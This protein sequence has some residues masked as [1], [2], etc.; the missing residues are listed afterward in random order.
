VPTNEPLHLRAS[1]SGAAEEVLLERR[2]LI[3]RIYNQ[4]GESAFQFTLLHPV[5]LE[6]CE[7][8]VKGKRFKEDDIGLVAGDGR[9]GFKAHRQEEVVSMS[10]T[11][12]GTG[13]KKARKTVA[14]PRKET[15][16]LATSFQI[17]WAELEPEER[18]RRM[19]EFKKA[20][21]AKNRNPGA[22]AGRRNYS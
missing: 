8:V 1:L 20:K 15:C 13:W 18:A 9:F 3:P 4:L 2:C 19:S 6:Y 11:A 5:P 22:R 16:K 12:D 7:R 10:P 17:Y 14:R 21:R